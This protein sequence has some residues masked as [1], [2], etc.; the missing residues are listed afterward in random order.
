MSAARRRRAVLE[1]RPFNHLVDVW[2]VGV[3]TFILL[4]GYAPFHASDVHQLFTKI[5]KCDLHFNPKYWDKISDDAKDFIKQ[6]L[7]RDPARRSDAAQLLAHEWIT[8]AH[9]TLKDRDISHSLPEM[10]G[11]HARRRSVSEKSGNEVRRPAEK[12]QSGAGLNYEHDRCTVHT[13]PTK[14]GEESE[15]ENTGGAKPGEGNGGIDPSDL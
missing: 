2:S 3:I 11:W 4:G 8:H 13:G 1:G 12:R 14:A 10:A 9:T 7:T 15:A 6:M 5:R